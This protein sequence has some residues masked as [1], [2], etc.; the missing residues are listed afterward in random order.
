M[1][2]AQPANDAWGS[3]VPRLHHQGGIEF[4]DRLAAETEEIRV[5]HWQRHRL[6]TLLAVVEGDP[7]RD[8][9]ALRKVR[10]VWKDGA[11]VR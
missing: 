9:G 3:L 2:R 11:R 8:V 7:T 5:E 4:P 1:R 6:D 10:G